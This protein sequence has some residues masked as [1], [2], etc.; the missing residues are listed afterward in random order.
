MTETILSIG[1]LPTPTR[2]LP[3]RILGVDLANLLG[4][5]MTRAGDDGRCRVLACPPFPAGATPQVRVAAWHGVLHWLSYNDEPVTTCLA[6]QR[7]HACWP[8]FTSVSAATSLAQLLADVSVQWPLPEEDWLDL[9]DPAHAELLDPL[10]CHVIRLKAGCEESAPEFAPVHDGGAWR[11]DCAAAHYS[12]AYQRCLMS[13]WQQFVIALLE[14]P[15]ALLSEQTCLGDARGMQQAGMAGPVVPIAGSLTQRFAAC[16]TA[17]PDKPAVVDDRGSISFAQLDVQSG[18]WAQALHAAGVRR[19]DH[20]GVAFGRSRAMVVAQLAVLKTGAAFVPMDAMQPAARLQAMADD[21]DMRLA[22]SDAASAPALKNALPGVQCLVAD[23]L[24]ATPDASS[25]AVAPVGTD[26]PAYVIFTSGSTGRP[27]GVKV[28]HGNLLNFVVHLGEFVGADDV[29]SQFA[30]FTFDA[31]VAE[32]HAGIL[33][34]V[35]LVILSGELINDPDRLQVYMNEQGVTFAAFPPQ[36]A[37]HLSPAKLPRLKTLLTAGSAPDHALVARWQPHLRYINA[38]GP[39]ETTILS[40]AWQ[41]SR[42]PGVH[43]PIVIGTPICNTQVRVANRFNQSLPPGVIGELLIG[44][45]GVTHGYIKRNALTRERFITL[46]RT[47]WYRSGDLACLDADGRLIF[48]GR[49]DSQI[50]L[51]GHRLE[52]GEVEA[53]LLAVDGIRQAAVSAVDVAAAK[54]LVAFCVGTPQP[55]EG[56]RQRLLQLLPAW[57][58]PNRIVWLE[59]L[60]LTSNGKTDYRSLV[61]SLAQAQASTEPAEPADHADALEAQIA[62]IWRSVLQQPRISRDDNFIHLGGDSLTAL[63]VT[64]AVKRLGYQLTSAQLLQHPRL[65]DCAQLLRA[66]GQRAVERDHASHQGPAPLAPIQGWFFSLSLAHPGTFCQSLVFESDE[67]IDVQRLAQACARLAGY[68]DQL[69]ARF[70]FDK[71]SAEWRQEILPDSMAVPAPSVI[72]I[73]D[74][75]L[76][77]TS[78][79]YCRYLAAELHLDAAP[80]FRLAVINSPQRSRVVWVLHHLIVDTVSHGILLNDLHQLYRSAETDLTRVLPGK[81]VAFGAW[82]GRLQEQVAANAR[83]LLTWW[84]PVLAALRQADALP[85]A[86][87]RGTAAPVV[88]CEARLSRDETKLLIEDATRCY[89][90]RPEE[91]VLA[92]TYR[93]LAR[94]LNVQRVAIDVE[95][96]GRDEALAGPQGVDRTVGWFTSVHPLCMAVPADQ[97]LGP[98]LMALKEAR[99]AIPHRGREFYALR[100]LS[101]NPEV[102]AEFVGYRQPE[103]LFNFSGVVQRSHGGWRTVP[104]AAVEMGEGNA[105]PYALSVETEIRDG[106]LIVSCYSRPELWPEASVQ[107]LALALSDGLREII[108]HCCVAGHRRW[109]PSD[110]PQLSLTQSQV[111]ELPLSSRAAYPLTDMQQTM[112]RHKDTYQVFMC[113]RLPR[114]FDEPA[115]R[116]AVADW[117]GRHDCLRSHV[118]EWDSGDVCQVVLDDLPPPMTVHQVRPGTGR[119]LAS[120]LIEQARREPVRVDQAPL[121][122]LHAID[123]AQDDFLIVLSIHHIIHDGWSI[124]LLLGDLL[125]SYRHCCAGPAWRTSSPSKAGCEPARI[126]VPI[127]PSCRGNARQASC[128][129]RRSARRA[130][131]AGRSGATRSS[132]SV[133]SMRRW[134]RRCAPRRTR[135]A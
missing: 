98:W 42:V 85:L 44:G 102:R 33:N 69:R 8:I 135:W 21:T 93:A 52:P 56:L 65:A 22:L 96:H 129:A 71:A 40:T 37:Q 107:R 82:A 110:F 3:L 38:Y 7:A 1:Q 80:L 127:G 74:A 77:T 27:K 97:D 59:R 6:G 133:R 101:R 32:I 53:A 24:P 29:V 86:R 57:A 125:Q 89:R 114:R 83:Q 13:L 103:V 99:A 67:R 14:C 108:R 111:D 131:K 60:P 123:E 46:D 66:G 18:A 118:K 109:T 12:E 106:K 75:L 87:D 63:V 116:A 76:D 11:S 41:P 58:L 2:K 39:T 28:S 126:G 81:S 48:A 130:P 112:W 62:A 90:Q 47:R 19:G 64:S 54:Q 122:H 35:T 4:D 36:Y 10:H 34:G 5:G 23:E 16:A 51:R 115:W 17:M 84:R 43:E 121:F 49:V 104:I 113:Y 31:S 91:L 88:V 70:M 119:D 45:E 120:E 124:E 30:P 61:E 9:R 55:E 92:A 26:D 79:G 50:K 20:V 25:D 68:H 73:A 100:Y 95:W 128:L 132:I 105:N 78:E 134:R 94:S 72:E 15:H 117:I